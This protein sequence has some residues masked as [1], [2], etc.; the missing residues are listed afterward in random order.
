MTRILVIDDNQDLRDL[1]K[2]ILEQAGYAVELAEDGSGHGDAARAACGHRHHRHLHARTRTASR[3]SR[4]SARNFR[5][6]S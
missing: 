2:V 4:S 3:P 5:S 1:M 6:S